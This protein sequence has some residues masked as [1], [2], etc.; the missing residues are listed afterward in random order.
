MNKKFEYI[1]YVTYDDDDVKEVRS[2]N[3]R[4]FAAKLGVAPS[5]IMKC[6]KQESGPRGCALARRHIKISRSPLKKASSVA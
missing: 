4:D 1:A 2:A 5:T 6:L 3:M